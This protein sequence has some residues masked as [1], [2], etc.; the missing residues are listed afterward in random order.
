MTNPAFQITVIIH[1]KNE[2]SLIKDCITSAYLLA[3]YVIVADMNSSDDTV[4]IAKQMKAKV[5]HFPDHGYADPVRQSAMKQATTPWV[6]ML[7]ADERMTTTL[8]NCLHKIV[9]DDA[10]EA[11]R[12]P[13]QNFVCGTWLKHGQ[14]WPDYKTNF[15]KTA[16]TKCPTLPHQ[17]PVIK[18]RILTLE[19]SLNNAIIHYNYTSIAQL[20]AKTDAYTSYESHWASQKKVTATMVRDRILH[21]FYW[22]FYEGEGYKDGMS[23]WVMAKFMEFYRFLEFVKFWEKAGYPKLFTATQ[24]YNT[25]NREAYIQNLE[26]ELQTIKASKFYKLGSMYL[27]CKQRI[28]GFLK[29]IISQKST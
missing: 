26:N 14:R 17:S 19:A 25:W 24:L 12:I 5:L 10:A 27:Q 28:F 13:Y 3:K 21:D 29:A 22:R 20:L 9:S 1:V 2:Q 11:V 23:G 8:A 4:K 16:V 18:G 6:L 7:D 15:F